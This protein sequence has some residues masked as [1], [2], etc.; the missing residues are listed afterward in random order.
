MIPV[1]AKKL[2]QVTGGRLISA[3]REAI[4]GVRTDSRDV[5][6]GELFI[7][8]VGERADGHDY[9]D[10]AIAKGAAAVITARDIPPAEGITVVRVADTRL[11]MKALASYV[12]GE[13]DI[14]VVAIIGSVGKTTT[15]DM[16]AGIL[17]QRF[18]VLKTEGNYNN[19]IGVPLTLFRLE[20]HHQCAVIEMGMNHFGEIRYLAEMVRPDYVVMTNIGDAHI[21]NLGSREGILKAKSEVFEFVKESGCAVLNGDDPLLRTLRNTLKCGIILC[22]ESLDCDVLVDDVNT[23]DGFTVKCG[24]LIGGERIEADIPAPGRHMVYCAAQGA[25]IAKCLGMTSEEIEKGISAYKPTGMRMNIKHLSDGVILLDDAYNANPQSMEAS[26]RT[27]ETLAAEK[28]IAVLGDM[29]ELGEIAESAHSHIGDICRC[30]GIDMVLTCGELG[31]FI[32]AHAGEKGRWYEDREALEADLLS[33]ITPGTAIE[34][35]ASRGMHFE[36]FTRKIEEK[37]KL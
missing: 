34:V 6:P 14:P 23:G 16:V 8:I 5:R 35:K 20:E 24:I 32:A 33:S 37:F 28:K 21:E 15:K 36:D 13:M 12:R 31:R 29:L 10:Q 19:D 22:G 27:L 11:A 7:P 26:L 9:I 18:D 4:T 17:G 25:Y 3:G 30:S 1:S 2:A